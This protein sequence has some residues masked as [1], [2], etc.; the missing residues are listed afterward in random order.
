MAI[1]GNGKL[2]PLGFSIHGCII[3]Y[4]KKGLRLEV[5]SSNKNP[6]I[7]AK[8]YMDATTDLKVVSTYC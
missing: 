8:L 5:S 3:G 1:D 6:H 4:S 7:V 2:K